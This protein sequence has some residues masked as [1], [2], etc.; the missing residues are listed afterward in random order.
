MDLYITFF[1]IIASIFL[2]PLILKRFNIPGIT[3]IMLAGII[4][5]PYGLGIVAMDESLETFSVFGAIFL[6]FLAGMEVD[7]ETLLKGFKKSLFISLFSA[8]VC[9]IGGYYIG[10]FLGLSHMGSLLYG[11]LFASNSVGIVYALLN[12]LDMIKSK[13]GTVLLGAVVISE[14]IGLIL[15]AIFSEVNLSQGFGESILFI[16]EVMLYIIGLLL[17]VPYIAKAMFKRCEKLHFRKI[18]FILLIIL[19]SILVGEYVGLHPMIGAFITGVAVSEALTK[20]E[21]DNLLNNNLNA[22]GYGLFIPIFFLTLGMNTDVRMLMNLSNLEAL[23]ATV[24]GLMILKTISGYISFKL[25]GYDKLKS[26]YG[27]L[28]TI[29]Q[30]SAPLV[31]VSIGRDL[32]ILP[33]KFF[34]TVI[35]LILITSIVAPILIRHIIN[36]YDSVNRV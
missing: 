5:G 27:G 28:L 31:V 3:A 24:G 13:F 9:G 20:E 11:A 21:H 17:I 33:H 14:L 22:I 10:N 19:I 35:V 36:K 23:I 4:I 29:P 1:I 7:N 8:V 32:G 18:H 12:E 2:V 6:M 26:L 25:V 30:V 16:M 34:V 15:L